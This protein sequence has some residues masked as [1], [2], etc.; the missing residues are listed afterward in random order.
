VEIARGTDPAKIP[1]GVRQ[2]FYYAD[3]ARA[4]TRLGGRDREAIRYLL[5][6]ERIAPQHVRTS[7]ELAATIRVLLDRSRRQAGGT[8]LRGLHERMQAVASLPG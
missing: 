1:A 6:A 5:T 8:E 4:L 2:V 7:A 3:T